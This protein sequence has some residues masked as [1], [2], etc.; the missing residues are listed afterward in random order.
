MDLVS[1][2]RKYRHE[3]GF[4]ACDRSAFAAFQLRG[5]LASGSSNRIGARAKRD[6]CV[7]KR[8]ILILKIT[9]SEAIIIQD[10]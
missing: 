1:D 10:R 8:K 6:Y 3:H 9:R 7:E 2:Y 4:I 5:E